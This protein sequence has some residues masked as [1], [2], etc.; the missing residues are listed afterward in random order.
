LPPKQLKSLGAA[1]CASSTAI[2]KLIVS[3]NVMEL[4]PNAVLARCGD[5]GFR[6]TDERQ[7]CHAANADATVHELCTNG[8]F[9]ANGG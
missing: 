3:D 6:L 5:S 7:L 2:C 9:S 4:T 8:L 1:P